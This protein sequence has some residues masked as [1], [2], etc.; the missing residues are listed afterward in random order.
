MRQIGSGWEHHREDAGEG[1]GR[2]E[3]KLET[4]KKMKAKKSF[5]VF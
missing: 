3:M 4:K 2:V 1:N 5:L